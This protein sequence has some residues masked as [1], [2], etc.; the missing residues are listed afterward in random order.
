MREFIVRGLTQK[1]CEVI[2]DNLS[3]ATDYHLE[4]NVIMI[5][6]GFA[7][8]VRTMRSHVRLREF[9]SDFLSLVLNKLSSYLCQKMI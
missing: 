8:I 1:Q 3:G 5:D 9:E 2:K 4:M 7:L 6:G